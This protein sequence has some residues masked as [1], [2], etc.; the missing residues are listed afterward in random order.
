VK[1]TSIDEVF[2]L[3]EQW[4][5]DHY[6]EAIS[7]LDHAT[8]TAARAVQDGASDALVAAALLHD[9]GHL[10]DL[11]TG[12]TTDGA[13]APHTPTDDLRHEA[14]GARYLGGLL[15]PSVTAPIA[16]HVLAKR[17]RGAVDPAYLDTLSDGSRASLIL[18]GG[19]FTPD[20]VAAFEIRP[21][22]DDAVALRSWDDGGKI[23]GLE[24]PGLE[25]Y[26]A[27]LEQLCGAQ[28]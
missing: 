28:P 13:R 23:E 14:T 7:Q 26:R 11:A 12:T 25:H 22:A 18:Q 24:T 2:A 8:Q 19:P 1:A 20:Q 27:R 9:V 10:L 5:A 17:Y 16:L 6:D 21:G 15:P 4:G 3:Y